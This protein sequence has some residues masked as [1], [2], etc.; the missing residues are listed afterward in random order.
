[1]LGIDTIIFCIGIALCF[2]ALLGVGMW[3]GQSFLGIAGSK[4]AH[5]ESSRSLREMIR[6]RSANKPQ[7]KNDGAWNGY[8]GFIVTKLVRECCNT[9]SVYLAPEDGKPIPHFKPGQHITLRF[10]PKGKSK[11]LVRCYSLSGPPGKPWYR[12]S[13]KHVADKGNDQ[14]PGLVSTI[15][16]CETEVG[17]RIPIKAPSG[18]FFLDEESNDVLVLLAGGIGITPMISMMEHSIA[19]N[20]QR[21]IVLVH[22]SRNGQE[23]QF[24][25]YLNRCAA[26]S[27]RVHVINCY[28]QPVA[29]DTKGVDYQIEGKVTIELLQAV[30][31]NAHCQ[32]YLCGPPAFMESLHS[33]LLEWRVD[34]SRIRFEQFGPSTIK[35]KISTTTAALN[36]DEPDPVSFLESDEI[37]LWTSSY[38]SL[39]ELAEA[40]DVDIESGCRAGSCGTCETAIVSGKVRYTTGEEVQCNPGCCLPCIAI[41]DGPLELEA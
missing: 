19:T 33:G 14:G 26:S 15:V 36:H 12:I 4:Q 5:Q 11:P 8:R 18:S 38:E 6:L 29:Q 28:S 35:K 20:P 23:Q 16:N 24:K 7:A 22:G 40:N 17:D 9:V 1:M 31:P 30:L 21:S 32:F 39:L 10:Q 27:D 34:E 13:V 37:A 3:A 41:P 2:A 25:E